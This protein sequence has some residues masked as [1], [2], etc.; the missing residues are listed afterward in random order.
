[1]VLPMTGFVRL[2][3][4]LDYRKLTNTLN[5]ECHFGLPKLLFERHQIAFPM[6]KLTA[7]SHVVWA[8]QDVNISV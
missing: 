4:F 8:E 2:L 5:Q 3:G 7:I 1:M 6:I